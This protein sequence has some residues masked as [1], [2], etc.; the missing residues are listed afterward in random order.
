MVPL[1]LS[2][3]CGLVAQAVGMGQLTA[4]PTVVLEGLTSEL[5]VRCGLGEAASDVSSVLL[6]QLEKLENGHQTPIA[7]LHDGQVPH[8]DSASLQGRATLSGTINHS[9]LA[10]SY[11]SLTIATP[12]HVDTG[13]YVCVLM[14]FDNDGLLSQ[15]QDSILVNSTEASSVHD[16]HSALSQVIKDLAA[17]KEGEGT[18]TCSCGGLTT[19][20]AQ[21]EQ[22]NTILL[23]RVTALE[24]GH[25]SHGG[26]SITTH[27]GVNPVKPLGFV[28]VGN[29]GSVSYDNLI[30]NINGSF[31]LQN[32]EFIAPVA[33]F[34]FFHAFD[35]AP[36]SPQ[37]SIT[38]NNLPLAQTGKAV[39]SPTSNPGEQVHFSALSVSG[40]FQLN[41]GDVVQVKYVSNTQSYGA[42]F[43]G[44]LVSANDV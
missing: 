38:V 25:V 41:V 6:M 43:S 19:K 7:T 42:S 32:D 23:Q 40:L 14:T 15:I 5:T 13:H 3:L 18:G 33:G 39:A 35:A 10:N 2:V 21:L 37:M 16:L 12:T 1:L 4:T 24:G 36:T 11:L 20:V 9:N 22:A 34:Y 44:A 29:A 30:Y 27:P 28:A 26:G 31:D 17:L 8:L